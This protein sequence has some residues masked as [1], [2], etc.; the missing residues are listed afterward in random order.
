MG[1]RYGIKDK[2]PRYIYR[3]VEDGSWKRE[4]V[5]FISAYG[6]PSP[7]VIV[8]GTRKPLSAPLPMRFG[9]MPADGGNL[10]IEA[11]DY[12][13]FVY[14]EPAAKRW[15]KRLAGAEEFINN[16]PRYCLWLVG[17]TAKDIRSMPLV[18]KRVQACKKVREQGSQKHLADTPHLFRDTINPET[19]I[20][21]PGVSSENRKYIP[22]GFIDKNT[23]A[24]N[25]TLFIAG[26][27]IYEFSILTSRMHM[28][29]MRSKRW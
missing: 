26:A 23:I 9:N 19:A 24:T 13:K 21:V 12:E 8:S 5:S 7:N 14:R 17:A 11:E 2:D 10:I 29:W 15:I 22:L 18:H 6:L 3:Q 20:L 16:T 27:G 25:A 1:F 28:V 4:Q